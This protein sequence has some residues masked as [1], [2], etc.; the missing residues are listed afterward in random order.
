VS[1]PRIEIDRCI[2]RRTPFGELLPLARAKGWSLDDLVR[3]TGCGGQCG[4]C[5]PYL[6]RMLVTGETVFHGIIVE[7]AEG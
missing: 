3:E 5:R 2:C 4:L 1:G 6:R 7:G